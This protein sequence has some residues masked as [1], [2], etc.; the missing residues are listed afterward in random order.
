MKIRKN[1]SQVLAAAKTGI[2]ERSARRIESSVTLRSQNPRRYWRS[3]TDPFA[4]VWDTEVVPLLKSAPKL[5]AIT[6]LRKLQD[7][8][9]GRFPD[10]VLRTLQRHIRQWRA[11]EGPPKEVF[12][13]QE[14]APGH[15]GLSDFTAMGELRI[16]IASAPFAHIL[17]HF[18]LAFS[19]W[20]H[21][22]V[23][24]GGE[25]FEALS[26]GLQNALWQAGGAPKEH[27]SDSLSAA[28]KNLTE[29]KDFTVRYTGLLDHY[30]MAGTRNNR[31]VS[32]ENGSVES[33]HRYLKEAIEQALLLRGHRD[34][35]NRAAYEAFVREAVMRRNR[36]N[37][38][39]FRIEREQLQDLPVQRTTDFVEEEARVTRCSTFTVRAILY[40]APSRLIGHLLKVRLYSDRLDCY[41]SGALVLTRARGTRSP[42]TGR[43][44]MIDYRHFIDALKRKPQ[45]FKGL[46]FRDALFPREAYRRTWE[47]LDLKLTQRQ[48]CQTIVALLEMAARDGVEG[49]L[50]ER[51][52]ALLVAGELPDVKRLREE[53][54]PR[55]AELPQVT[56]EIP[57]ASV[58][59][60]LLPSEQEDEPE[61]VAA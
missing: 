47:Q 50:A 42:I 13:P 10:G 49:A 27:R 32:H 6:L 43:G 11:L 37:A 40:S 19:R 9:P 33:S 14:H 51:L 38:A 31:G 2:S 59:D 45:A 46:A 52:D 58:Y 39:A 1:K 4:Q 30:G 18:V 8:H 54:A 61:E 24:E 29:E 16:T 21:V 41:L 5:M 55:Q 26:K 44:R 20:E 35:E 15:R 17:Y 12:F 3:R 34:F 23:V 22:E 28:F 7:D 53:F 48:A 57:A 25:S 56:V 60:A 36:R